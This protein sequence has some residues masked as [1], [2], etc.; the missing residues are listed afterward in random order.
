MKKILLA[1]TIVGMSAYSSGALAADVT[2]VAEAYDWTGLYAGISGGWGFN[3]SDVDY[4]CDDLGGV[5]FS[6]GGPFPTGAD[7]DTDG[8]MLGGTLGAN[9]QTGMWVLGVEGDMS[10]TDWEDDESVTFQA[11]DVAS[12]DLDIA[13]F[14]TARARLGIATDRMLIYAT[15]GAA[16]A[17]VDL[18]T[19]AIGA[20]ENFIGSNN[21]VQVG[22]TAGGGVEF[23]A[24]E[25]FTLKAEALYY[26][27]GNVSATATDPVNFPGFSFD[28]DADLTGVIVRAGINWQF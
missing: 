21:G 27:L 4:D 8:A 11:G 18:S 13:W 17:D 9:W 20:P 7:L 2:P 6:V 3:N 16:F 14:A 22:W 10:W 5:C 28:G 24:S 23:A 25:Q 19:S 26:D 1:A 15:G 12:A